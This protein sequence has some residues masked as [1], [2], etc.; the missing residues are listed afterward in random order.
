MRDPITPIP[1]PLPPGEG[2][3]AGQTSRFLAQGNAV[4]L[5]AAV[6]A[7]LSACGPDTKPTQVASLSQALAS[8]P[9]QTAPFD[10]A[11]VF[12]TTPT[13]TCTVSTVDGTT[14]TTEFDWGTDPNFGSFSSAT[15]SGVA[16]GSTASYTLTAGQALL[17]NTTYYWRARSEDNGGANGGWSAYTGTRSFTVNTS[18]TYVT[19]YQATQWQFGDVPPANFSATETQGNSVIV[20]FNPTAVFYDNFSEGNLNNWTVL[21]TQNAQTCTGHN[22]PCCNPEAD[23]SITAAVENDGE[24][25][26]GTSV[27]LFQDYDT[28]TNSLYAYTNFS[29]SGLGRGALDFWSRTDGD[30]VDIYAGVIDVNSNINA[31][32]TLMEYTG[33]EQTWGPPSTNPTLEQFAPIVPYTVNLWTHYRMEWTDN[34]SCNYSINGNNV[35]SGMAMSYSGAIT[36]ILIYEP[37][38]EVDT[39]HDHELTNIGVFQGATTG[40][41]TGPQINASDLGS[42]ASVSFADTLLTGQTVS[43]QVQ[44]LT[45]GSWALV[46]DAT[47]P[48]NST[49]F[50]SPPINISGLS[51]ASYPS[52][53]LVA[54][55]TR[56]TNTAVSPSLNSWTVVA[57]PGPATNLVM[58]SGNGQ[59]GTVGQNLSNPFVVKVTDIRGNPVPGVTVS[60]TVTGGGGSIPASAITNASGL[61]SVTATL[62]TLAGNNTYSASVTG[63]AG[64]PQ[65]FSATGLAAA[66]H[67]LVQISGNN[68]TGTVAQALAQPFVVQVNDQYGNPVSNVTVTFAEKTG[69]GSIAPP[70]GTTNAAGQTSATGTLGI[71]AGNSNNTFTATSAGLTGSPQTFTASANAGAASQIVKISGDGQTGTVNTA[72][73]QPFVVEVI[74]TYGNAVPN[75]IVTFAVGIGSGSIMPASAVTSAGGTASATGALGPTAGMNNNTFTVGSGS[76]PQVTFT[77]SANA[78]SASIMVMVSGNGQSGTVG[79]ALA[80]PLVVKVQDSSNNPVSGVTVTFAALSGGGS[81]STPSVVTG[82]NGLAS[83]AATLGTVAGS[84]NNT[85]TATSP[86]LTGSPQT[87]TASANAGAASALVKISGDGQSGTVGKA[88][89]APFVVQVNDSYGNG[90]SGATVTFQMLTGGGSVNPASAIT[91]SSGQAS[92]TGTLGTTAGTGNNTFSATCGSIG[93]QTFTASGIA[94][95]ATAIVKVSGDNQNGTVGKALALPLVVQVNDTYGNAVSGTTVNFASATGSVS[96]ASANTG[97]NGQASTIATLGTV[98]GSNNNTFTATSGTLTGSPLT[99][100]ASATA[101]QASVLTKVSGDSQTG[102]VGAAL[103]QPFVVQVNDSFNNPVSGVNVS[104][105]VAMGGGSINPPTAVTAA[106]GKAQAIGTLGTTSGANAD[107]FTAS[108]SGVTGSPQTFTATANAGTATALLKVSGDG[109]SGKVSQTLTAPLVVRVND[110]YGNPVSGVTI[111]FAPG[112]S[113]GGSVAPLT[114]VTG[115]SGTAS[116]TATLGTTAGPDTFTA[117]GANLTPPS[118]TFNETA[119]AGNAGTIVAVSGNGQSATV[120]TALTLPLVVKVTDSLNNPVSGVSVTFAVGTAGVGSIMPASASTDGTGQASATATL[121]T[122][123]ATQTFTATSTGLVGSPITFSETATPGTASAVALVATPASFAA[124]GLANLTATVQDSYKNTV[125][126]FSQTITFTVAT[127]PGGT[128][129][130]ATPVTPTNGVASAAFSSS[131]VGVDNLVASASGAANGTTTVTVTS[132]LVV[133]LTVAGFP[134][135]VFAGASGSFTVTAVDS[136]SNTVS[137]YTGKVSFASS[138]PAAMLPATYTFVAGDAGSHT[139]SATLS[140]PGTQTITV[141]DTSTPTITGKQSGIVVQSTGVAS[142]KVTGVA[143]PADVGLPYSVTV[144]ALDGA[145]NVYPSYAGTVHFTSTDPAANLPTDYTFVSGDMGVHTFTNGVIFNTLGTQTL[146]VN[147]V[148]KPTV[149]GQETGIVVQQPTKPAIVHD[150]NLQAAVGVPYVYN[151]LETITVVGSLPMTFGKCGGP[152]GFN[153]DTA[154]GSVRWT[155]AT[156]GTTPLCVS[157]QNASGQDQYDFSVVV[158]SRPPTA[159]TAAFTATPSSGMAPL[160]VGFDASASTAAANALPLMFTWGFGDS[161]SPGSGV[162]RSHTFFLPG[163]YHA[164]LTATD[165]FGDQGFADSEIAASDPSGSAPPT[166]KIVASATTGTGSLAV[167]FSCDCQQGTAPIASYVWSLGDGTTASSATAAD[168]YAPGRYHVTLTVVDADGV[169]AWDKVEIAVSQGSR[170]PPECLASADPPAGLIPL[171]TTWTGFFASTQGTIVSHQWTFGPA[172][173]VT[174]PMVMRQ[175]T[176]P[177]NYPGELTAVDDMGLQCS[178]SVTV[179]ALSSKGSVPPT[180]ISSPSTTAECDSPYQYSTS[181]AAAA[182]GSPTITWATGSGSPQGFTINPTTGAVSWTPEGSQ[183]GTQNIV[184]VATN[185]AGSNQQTYSVNVSCPNEVKL[186][187]GCGCGSAE[188]GPLAGIIGLLLAARRRR[189]SLRA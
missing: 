110:T 4:G 104:F 149:K 103:S 15:V 89:A 162:V 73:P 49:G 168:T 65:N 107:T 152:A 54:T 130:P 95:A 140:S 170:Q 117:A 148:A 62:G 87:F 78:A 30:N 99:F 115:T 142:L 67:T 35:G 184:I 141:T 173:T 91:T 144:Q 127:G 180:I 135:P 166:A 154:T 80:A 93:S 116:T 34:G 121:G 105:A 31:A 137:G 71:V 84:S 55:L 43:V 61:A 9:V 143:S 25:D 101:G 21:P 68:Q 32:C 125:T 60:Y 186:K 120:G 19:W 11:V 41:Y 153:V 138:D 94:G 97:A 165:S 38:V 53:R 98:A 175:Y 187:Y 106:N 161:S 46:P 189:R 40:R 39:I 74:D 133:G 157:A 6:V 1:P 56:A 167:N 176:A 159:V 36:Y 111:T 77:A 132:G 188:G 66:A 126:S 182:Q 160:D 177:G 28:T 44:Y 158:D 83:T 17:N 47:L 14:I 86:G 85:F 45:G 131:K 123:A 181:G 13:M 29:G 33:D 48:G 136:Y 59:T 129:S 3:G 18:A 23:C 50:T 88:L 124:G 81:V 20:G 119:L 114:G 150:A 134:S 122:T 42:W 185:A 102:T 12:T 128:F 118:V 51:P 164:R 179:T 183:G 174:A 26:G 22:N 82:S 92:T 156:V 96:P 63:L 16:S 172:D 139:F 58:V 8:V 57:G 100:T 147:D 163:G 76:L 178:D 146:T 145:Q 112:S 70:S 90:V 155:P 52:I 171:T 5:V 37:Y 113:G 64:S 10:F 79:T 2:R 75:V 27:M 108:V 69:G 169:P 151:P 24:P 72:L 109:Q 7:L